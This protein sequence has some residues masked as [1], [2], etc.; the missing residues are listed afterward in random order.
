MNEQLRADSKLAAASWLRD[1]LQPDAVDPLAEWF[2]LHAEV[3]AV[4]KPIPLPQ[5]LG[6][7]DGLYP[8]EWV[9][10]PQLLECRDV[11]WLPG[12]GCLFHG[13]NG[14]ALPW[15]AFSRF[16]R[17]RQLPQQTRHRI[18]LSRPVQS[19]QR[20]ERALWL[21]RVDGSVFGEWLT[22]VVA[23]LWPF[24]LTSPQ[25]LTGLPVLLGDDPEDPLLAELHRLMRISIGGATR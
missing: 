1:P 6:K 20:L 14:R 9:A 10:E 24:L 15:S 17:Q 22:E 11:L 7:L 2:R 18:E 13:G 23:F 3:A 19:F 5:L 21:P 4:A 8:D 12:C 16:P 25:E